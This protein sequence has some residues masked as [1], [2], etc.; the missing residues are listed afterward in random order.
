MRRWL[1]VGWMMAGIILFAGKTATEEILP[2][3]SAADI[4][5]P[6][7]VAL[8]FD[9]GPRPG[10][11]ERLLEELRDRGAR[12]TFFLIGEQAQM[13]PE[14]VQMIGAEGHQVGNHT[15][16]HVCLQDLNTANALAEV[17]RADAVLQTIL[18]PGDYWV[19]PPYG[20]VDQAFIQQLSVPVIKWSV[21]PRDWESRNT[22]AV[23]D[24]VME[25]VTDGSIVLLHDI[26][27]TSVEAAFQ[28]IDLLEP[29]GYRFVTVEQLLRIKGIEP[30]AGTAYR[31]ADE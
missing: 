7:Y 11:T 10:S 8:T 27:D 23:V 30:Q 2:A 6:R 15:W 3:D 24:A 22:Q 12:A 29:Q 21:D 16:G 20:L 5:A 28:I 14:L 26:Y 19:R 1:V 17:E 13:Y 9:D 25:T 4:P 31:K 18:G